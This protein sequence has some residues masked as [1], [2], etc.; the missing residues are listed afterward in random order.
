MKVREL[1][2]K[3]NTTRMQLELSEKDLCKTFVQSIKDNLK[4]FQQTQYSYN[5]YIMN[6]KEQI[7]YIK[8]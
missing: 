2:M 6:K 5:K 7:L 1:L 3:H 4:D 8:F